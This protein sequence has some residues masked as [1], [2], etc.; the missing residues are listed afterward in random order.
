VKPDDV[1]RIDVGVNSNVPNALIHTRPQTALNAKFSLQ[2]QMAI[3]VLDRAA[4]LAQFT[5]E[6]VLLPSTRAMIERVFVYVDPEIEALGFNEMR[7]K[8]AITLKDGR[9][10]EGFA[11]AAKGHPRKRMSHADVCEKFLDC[12][13]TVIPSS[14]AEQ[15]LARL[16]GIEQVKNV[17]ELSPL[18]AGPL[19]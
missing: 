12:A 19:A 4:G 1:E 18:L 11:D 10:L 14:K 7:M 17:T 16:E 15:L 2:F 3:G 5:D 9:K 6:K 13:A 8:V